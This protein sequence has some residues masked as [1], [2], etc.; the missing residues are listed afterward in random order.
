MRWWDTGGMA[1][2]RDPKRKRASAWLEGV[3]GHE[4]EEQKRKLVSM[5]YEV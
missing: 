1:L 5:L 2:G 3:V 4:Q